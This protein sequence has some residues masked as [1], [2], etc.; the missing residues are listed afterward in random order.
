MGIGKQRPQ[1]AGVT[2]TVYLPN[3]IHQRFLRAQTNM[4]GVFVQ[5]GKLTSTTMVLVLDGK[6]EKGAHVKCHLIC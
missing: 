1:T 3:W 2:S 4:N 6:S 5:V